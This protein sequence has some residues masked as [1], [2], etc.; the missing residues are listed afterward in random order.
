MILPK[1]SARLLATYF[2]YFKSIDITSV[3]HKEGIGKVVD[4]DPRKKD[5]SGMRCCVCKGTPLCIQNILERTENWQGI[6]SQSNQR[7]RA[8]RSA[9]MSTKL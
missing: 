7:L 3:D 9:L 6:L 8:Q 1:T 2:G 5:S 4:D